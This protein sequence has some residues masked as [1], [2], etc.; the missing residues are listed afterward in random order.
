[1][2]DENTNPFRPRTPADYLPQQASEPLA[3]QCEQACRETL[4]GRTIAMGADAEFIA[5]KARLAM[6][7]RDLLA[8]NPDIAELL[9]VLLEL[10]LL[11]Q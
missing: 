9:D 2:T 5:R 7:A 8:A 4:L 1:M 3:N 10:R 11:R 6:R